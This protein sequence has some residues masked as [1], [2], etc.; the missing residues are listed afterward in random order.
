[1]YK[2]TKTKLISVINERDSHFVVLE[3]R[4]T[5]VFQI[6]IKDTWKIE[7]EKVKK[8]L[9]SFLIFEKISS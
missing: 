3:N 8:L 4:S 2:L 6:S 5:A 7:T 9:N 1:M